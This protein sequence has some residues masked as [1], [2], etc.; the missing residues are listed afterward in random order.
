MGFTVRLTPL[1]VLP[2]PLVLLVKVIVSE[3]EP[4]AKVLTFFK[5]ETVTGR[6]APGARVPLV[7]ESLTQV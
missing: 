6:E 3:N 7:L 2:I 4:S 5:M 1:V